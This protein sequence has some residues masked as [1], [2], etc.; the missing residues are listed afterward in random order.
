[1]ITP[2]VAIA[3][4]T[5]ASLAKTNP[6][7]TGFAAVRIGWIAF[8]VPVLFV[9]SPAL[10]L[11]AAGAALMVDSWSAASLV[12]AV[13][14]A[15]WLALGRAR[16]AGLWPALWLVLFAVPTPIYVEGRLQTRSWE[17]KQTGEKKYSTEVVCENFKMLGR[18]EDSA[19]MGYGGGAPAE[20]AVAESP[21]TGPSP[22]PSN[23]D[24]D[25]PF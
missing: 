9:F 13:P 22:S 20:S 11:H 4:F 25:I 10:L 2:P 5:A 24:D 14:G 12:L 21:G 6:M 8:V 16:L 7:A 1:M 15:A 19:G 18:R 23:P 17:D 3:A